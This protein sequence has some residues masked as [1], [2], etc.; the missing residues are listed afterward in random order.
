MLIILVAFACSAKEIS[1]KMIV[2]M[3]L[4]NKNQKV[5]IQSDTLVFYSKLKS[6]DTANVI[7]C[8]EIAGCYTVLFFGSD[9]KKKVEIIRK[10][11][12]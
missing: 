3:V 5:S 7:E 12:P 9:G 6:I 10:N 8:S 11:S 1:Q 4:N 2:L